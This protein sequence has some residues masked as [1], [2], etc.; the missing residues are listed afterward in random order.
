MYIISCYALFNRD[1]AEG[2]LKHLTSHHETTETVSQQEVTEWKEKY[3]QSKEKAKEYS[4]L[5]RQG[6]PRECCKR[7]I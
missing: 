2:K 5:V 7:T 3:E 1:R 4:E 6:W